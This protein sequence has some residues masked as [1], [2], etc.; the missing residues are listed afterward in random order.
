MCCWVCW[1]SMCIIS[2]S[3][4]QGE[5]GATSGIFRHWH[6]KISQTT[7]WLTDVQLSATQPSQTCSPGSG[8]A[9]AENIHFILFKL[10][11]PFQFHLACNAARQRGRF[12][13]R[14]ALSVFFFFSLSV[15]FVNFHWNITSY[16]YSLWVFA[17]CWIF[18]TSFWGCE[19]SC[20][21]E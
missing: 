4:N 8:Q 16:F 5:E 11:R 1:A 15:P 13:I 21:K 12:L 20:V 2:Y 17:A 3:N 14:E 7:S 6:S 9:A 19:E 18:P 10:P